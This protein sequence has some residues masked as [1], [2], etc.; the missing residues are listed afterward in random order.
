MMKIM[1]KVHISSS[2]K[3]SETEL[4]IAGHACCIDYADIE[5]Q[6]EVH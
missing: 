5:V 6:K 3:W 2:F 1:A 4:H